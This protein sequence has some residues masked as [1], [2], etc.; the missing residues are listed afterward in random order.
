MA[1]HQRRGKL[2]RTEAVGAG[3]LHREGNPPR[4]ICCGI[5]VQR[6]EAAVLRRDH[7]GKAIT[8]V[9]AI[10]DAACPSFNLCIGSCVGER[11]K[12]NI[13][14]AGLSIERAARLRVV[15]FKRVIEVLPQ[16]R[17]RRGQSARNYGQ[18]KMLHRANLCLV[19]LLGEI[20]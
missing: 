18:L 3:V 17:S 1:C 5:A 4:P 9:A 10:G 2:L 15:S 19:A 13:N 20:C 16:C 12:V 6:H 11:A 7:A 14:G 8:V